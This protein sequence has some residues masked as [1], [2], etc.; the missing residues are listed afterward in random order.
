MI[1]A[2]SAGHD[3]VVETLVA[4]GAEIDAIDDFSRTALML[5][6]E[7]ENISTMQLLLS[8]NANV[9]KP[10]RYGET[11]LQLAK[12]DEKKQLLLE[13]SKKSVPINNGFLVLKLKIIICVFI[14]VLGC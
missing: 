13:H 5:A 7:F 12:S 8:L 9:M 11:A 14:F 1:A 10:D 6:V 3:V 2:S 4:F